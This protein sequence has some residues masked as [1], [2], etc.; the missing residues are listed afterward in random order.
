MKPQA[1][2]GQ[3]V[4]TKTFLK[5]L[6]KTYLGSYGGSKSGSNGGDCSSSVNIVKLLR[7]SLSILGEI[8]ILFNSLGLTK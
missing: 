8:N 6:S 5:V 7:E 3:E 2:N 1:Y 4:F